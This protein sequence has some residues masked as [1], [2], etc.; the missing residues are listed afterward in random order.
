MK[1]LLITAIEEFETD[2]INI[3]KHSGVKAF[4]YQSVKGYRNEKNEMS[5]WFGKDDIAVN[6]L[7]FTVFSDCNCVDDIYKNVNEFN[8]KQ[9]TV[10]RIHIATINLENENFK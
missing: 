4:S 2:V 9:K 7:L 5:N 3:L 8:Q 10:S 6:S 1:L